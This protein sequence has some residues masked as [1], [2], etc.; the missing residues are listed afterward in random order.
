LHSGKLEIGCSACQDDPELQEALG[1]VEP[2]HE[3]V[4]EIEDY[5]FF[6]CP[7]SLVSNSLW[8]WF[9]EFSYCKEFS[10]MPAFEKQSNVFI[11]AWLYYSMWYNKFNKEMMDPKNKST[12]DTEE[13]LDTLKNS[14]INR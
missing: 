8:E 4:W 14:F 6:S 7:I 11:E 5:E 1:C 9:T 3:A 2:A 12:T 10:V 13:S